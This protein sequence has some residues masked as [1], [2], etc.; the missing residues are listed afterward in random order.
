MTENE[1]YLILFKGK[2][3][4]IN[5]LKENI[6]FNNENLKNLDENT[7]SLEVFKHYIE[8]FITQKCTLYQAVQKIYMTQIKGNCSSIIIDK[9]NPKFIILGQKNGS[10]FI[11]FQKNKILISSNVL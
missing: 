8:Y 2:I 7:Q 5:E 1:D 10:F 3:D 4:N 9:N 6:D 11:N